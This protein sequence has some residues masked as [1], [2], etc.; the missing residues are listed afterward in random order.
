MNSLLE[1][2]VHQR[3]EL[4]LRALLGDVAGYFGCADD[5]LPLES[6]TGEIVS[7]MSSG[8]PV[9]VAPVVSKWSTL[10][11][12]LNV[13]GSGA[14]RPACPAD[15]HRDGLPDG[16]FG[17]VSNSLSAP[18]SLVIMPSRF[19]LTMASSRSPRWRKECAR[20]GDGRHRL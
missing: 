18:C 13:R 3:F 8:G 1:L 20:I 5:M 19:L 6:L 2:F 10:S 14:P 7:E 9:L 16:L 4:L 11:P 12:F 15:E 17:G